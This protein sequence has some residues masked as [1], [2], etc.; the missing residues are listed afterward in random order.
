MSDSIE[1][2][3]S[4]GSW[5]QQRP[6]DLDFWLATEFSSSKPEEPIVAQKPEK[7]RK[8]ISEADDEDDKRRR[9]TEAS[10][11]FRAKKKAREQAIQKEAKELQEKVVRLEE[12]IK[13]QEM[14][15]KWLRQLVNEKQQQA[16]NASGNISQQQIQEQINAAVTFALQNQFLSK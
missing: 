1:N 5:D 14:E 6:S 11:R 10:A 4:I 3:L 12:K 9:N 7:K 8:T 13:E 2:L 16:Q 15:I